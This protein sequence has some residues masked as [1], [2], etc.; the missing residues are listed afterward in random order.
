[1]VEREIRQSPTEGLLFIEVGSSVR[2]FQ[3][4]L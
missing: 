1:M 2:E 4:I 3:Q